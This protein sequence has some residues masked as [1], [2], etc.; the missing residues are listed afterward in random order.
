MSLFKSFALEAGLVIALA[1]AGSASG[2]DDKPKPEPKPS[3][4]ETK[5]DGSTKK[6]APT[7][8]KGK[9]VSRAYDEGSKTFAITYLDAKCEPSGF[10][11][12]TEE[13]DL[14]SRCT[15]GDYFPQCLKWYE[16]EDP[17]IRLPTENPEQ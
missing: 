15:E 4:V 12:I 1:L 2:C 17:G 5:P 14:N 8:C 13:Q 10:D 9:I 11:T 7:G 3:P 16:T 6:P